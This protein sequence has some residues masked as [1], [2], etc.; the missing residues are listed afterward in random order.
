MANSSRMFDFCGSLSAR[1][2]TSIVNMTAN[3]KLLM[4]YGMQTT[5][6]LIKFDP[7][8]MGTC[9]LTLDAT[10]RECIFGDWNYSSMSYYLPVARR[11]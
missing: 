3:Q 7:M 5:I 6:K 2:Y 8:T 10:S 9:T 1:M 4:T 11:E